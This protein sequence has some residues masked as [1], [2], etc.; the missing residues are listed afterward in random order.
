MDAS[1]KQ[2]AIMIVAMFLLMPIKLF[3]QSYNDLWKQVRQAQDKDLPKSAI[4]H[5]EKIEKKAQ[6]EN[7]YG[8]L[9][10]STLLHAQLMA[11]VAPDSLAPA[12]ARLE[13]QEEQAQGNAVLQAVY[14]AVLSQIYLRNHQLTEEWKTRSDDYGTKALAHPDLL[15]QTKAETYDPFVVK[16]KHSTMYGDDLLSV[17]GHELNAW[18]QL[19]DYYQK[20]GNRQA[21]CYTSLQQLKAEHEKVGHEA[22]AKSAYIRQLDSLI[23]VYGDLSEAGEIAMERYDYM[24]SH[25]D[26]TRAERAAWLQESIRRWGTW[27]RASQLR[28]QWKELINPYYDAQAPNSVSETG[29]QQTV[30]LTTLRNLQGLTMRV[31]QTKQKGDTELNPDIAE[32]YKKLK[33]ELKELTELRRQLTFTGHEEYENFEDSIQLDGLPAGVYMLEFESQPATKVSRALYFVSGMRIMMQHQPDK[34]I[35]YVVVDATT[36]QPVSSATLRLGFSNGWRKPQT[37]KNFTTD[38]KGEVI[39]RVEDNKNPASVFAFTKTDCYC[40]ESNSYGR[41]TYYEHQYNQ[42]HTDLFTDRSIYRP[43]QTVFVSAIVW[44]E[45]SELDNQ[46]VANSQVRFELRDANYKVVG[47]QQAVTDRFGKCGVQFTLPQGLLNGRFTIRANNGSSVSIRVEEYKRPTFQVEFQE[48]KESY[49]AGD[50]VRAEGKAVSYAGVPVQDAKVKYV[51]RRRVAYWWLSYS[52][53]WET[54]FFGSGRQEEVLHEGEAVTAEDGTF[55]VEMPLEV[56]KSDNNRP[57]YY[58]FVVEAD[59]TDVAGET[60]SGTLSLPLGTKPTAL[61]CDVPQKVRSDQMPKVTFNRYNAAGKAIEGTVKYRLDGGKWQQCPANSQLSIVNSQLKSGEHRIEAECGDDKVDVKFV[62]FGLDDK[63]PATKTDDWFYVS[64]SQFPGDGSPVTVQ[65]GASDPDLH[66]VYS[67]Y[68]GEELLESGSVEKN[69]ALINRKFKYEEEYGNGLL[70]T[71]AWVKNGQCHIHQQTIRRPMPDKRLKMT[72]KTFRDR[73]TPGQQ[74]EWQLKITKPDGSPADA[75]LMAVLYDKSLDQIASHQWSF[76]PSNYLPQPSTAWQWTSWGGINAR[77]SQNYQG[78]MVPSLQFSHFDSSVYP[79]YAYY[80]RYAMTGAVRVRGLAKASAPMMLESAAVEEKAIGAFDVAGNDEAAGEVLKAKEV[81]VTS[82][83]AKESDDDA[84][85]SKEEEVQVRENLQETAFCYPTLQTDQDGQ[86]VLKF[87]LPE[88][89]TTW[90]FMGISNTTDMLYGYIGAEAV[91]KKDVMIQPNVPRFVR[92][93]DE[94]QISA[95]IF[96][97]SDHAVSGQ[98]KLMLIDPETNNTVFEQQQAFSAES[99]KTVSVTFS[100]QPKEDYSLLICKV[101]AVGEG[102]SDGEQHYLPILPNREYVTKTV[103]FTQ[104]E[105][106]VK[107]IDLTKL[108]PAG[109]TQ[110]KLTVEYTNNPA[111]L[112]VQSLA[113]TGQPWEH[114]AIDQAASYYSNYLAKSLLD[115]SPQVK[116]VFEQWKRESNHNSQFS[117]LNSQLEKNQ[118]LKDIVLSE[119]PWVRAADRESEQKQRLGD[120][121]DENLIKNRLSTAV[122]KLKTLQNRDGSFSWYPGMIGSTMVTVTIEEMLTRLAVMT[123]EQKDVKQMGDKAFNYIGKEMVD[124][125]KEMKKME[126]KGYKPSF[127][128][129]TALRWLYICALDG[130]QLSKDVQN[131]NDYLYK[132][133]KKEIKHQTIYEKALTTIILSKHGDAKLA[134]QYVQSLKE[135]TVYTEEMGRYYDTPRASYSWYDYKIPTEVA[136]IEAI[137]TVSPQDVQTVDEMRRW[138]LQEKRTQ[139]WDTPINSVNAIYAFLNG[140]SQQ[141]TANSQQP[142]VLAIDG[143][144]IE[145]SKATAGV[146]YVKTAIMNSQGKTF[147]ATKTSEGTSWGAVYGQFFQKTS[148]IEASQSGIKVTREVIAAKPQSTLTSHLSPLTSHLSPLTSLKV[149]DR[150]KIRITIESERDL[151]FVQVVDRRAACMEPVKQLSGYHNGAYCSPKD[152][153]TH[154]FYY[155]ISK[156]KHMIETEYYIDRA[157]TYETG[158]C[159][160]GCAYA[161]EYR[162]TAPS[163]QFKVKNEK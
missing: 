24:A 16:G 127:P 153:A 117:T 142:T 118:E 30:R 94:A 22:Y 23:A 13:Q 52:W 47:E 160:V 7:A 114:S 11:E 116:G 138:L 60:H 25:T 88:C 10:R 5:L 162:A 75:S 2:K 158:T 70:I 49:Q 80:S 120:F 122:E 44:K 27:P 95:R 110:Q 163:M 103:P 156:G 6:S 126:K 63:K 4:A 71:Y 73:L 119:T 112:M 108:L 107:T 86:V 26:A 40:P 39:Y 111:W 28:N 151:D 84:G 149:G 29:K 93:G 36:G 109:T 14:D 74:E 12:V 58:S 46:A 92:M 38:S 137:Q 77:G 56:P 128:S 105:A 55:K 141:L 65:V 102:F 145:T 132:L 82:Q 87:T 79:R 123:G 161:P 62:V 45:V 31:Y 90:R 35:R 76:Y 54:G 154:Y 99:E 67:I 159:T 41:Y 61:T 48:Y 19:A 83:A 129:F 96:N 1:M 53:Y 33:G 144:P 72:W 140:Q 106:G 59:V 155:G 139:V 81:A 146:G 3:S 20:A 121:F 125:V 134:A 69:G 51:V 34:T 98:A 131:A 37:F 152:N 150:I 18:R 43:G 9:L 57:M 64:D 135:W 85:A 8:Q 21:A 115:Q 91:A 133:L 101:V 17:V 113:T 157:G 15:A 89:L 50:T 100:Y 143:A 148:D 42:I 124:L 66:I 78:L 97:T 104:H 32:D 68:T 136:A 130:R 147:T